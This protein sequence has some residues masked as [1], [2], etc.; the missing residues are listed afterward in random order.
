MKYLLPLLLLLFPLSSTLVP[1]M[2]EGRIRPVEVASRLWL[3]KL[4]HSQQSAL[5]FAWDLHNKG[6][7]P[8]QETPLFWIEHSATKE[9]LELDKKRS[10]F[11]FIELMERFVENR[12]TNLR[13]VQVWITHFFALHRSTSYTKA[14]QV[15]LQALCPGLWVSMQERLVVAQAPQTPPWHFLSAG[16]IIEKEAKRAV[17]EELIR[18]WVELLHFQRFLPI[19]TLPPEPLT[20]FTAGPDLHVLPGKEQWFPLKAL[21]LQPS[22]N[23][24]LFSDPLFFELCRHYTTQNQAALFEALD[25]GYLALTG[26]PSVNQL[27]AELFYYRAPLIPIAI[28]LYLAALTVAR[29]RPLLLPLAWCA[30]T[31]TL[32]LRCY[33]LQRAPVATMLDTLLFVPWIA[34]TFSLFRSKVL[35]IGASLLSIAL[36][37]LV[38]RAEGM[39]TLP[40]V[41]DSQYWLI[42]HVMLIVASYGIFLLS[43]VLS[44]LYLVLLAFGYRPDWH[45][46]I[47][48]LLYL[49]TFMLLSGTIL[50]GVWAAQSWGRFWDWDPKESWAFISICLYLLVIHAY[51]FKKIDQLGLAVG[52]I[53]GVWAISFTWYG[54]NY[55]LGRGLHSYGFGQGGELYYYLFLL[56]DLV[57]V[58][59]LAWRRRR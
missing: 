36:L 10:H 8:F 9:L 31:A 21:D 23:F 25:R 12:E 22:T 3:Y 13:V 19:H 53:V 35:Q 52:S 29:A 14:P 28:A 4:S 40:P 57:F 5:S 6:Y 24:T 39:E 47:L 32:A 44:H 49:G 43:G 18:I 33:I 34:V 46:T 20:L 15:E 55:I 26:Y 27:R 45:K 50:G 30:H 54:V 17:V 59:I 51:R 48:S 56:I 41:L 16:S 42:I 11:S 1:T 58:T 38:D 2:Y 7:E 37:A